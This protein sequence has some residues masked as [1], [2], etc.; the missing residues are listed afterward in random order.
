MLWTVQ[1]HKDIEH[2]ETPYVVKLHR[3]TPLA[4][5]LPVFTFQHPA[6]AKGPPD[7]SRYLSLEFKRNELPQ[8]TCHGFAGYFEA[9]L[10]GDVWLSTHPETHTPN[11]FSWFPVYFPLAEPLVIPQSRHIQ[12]HWWRCVSAHEVW[13]EWAVSEPVTSHIHNP[14]GRSYK[15]GL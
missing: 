3:Y 6:E 13:Y 2:M 9:Q 14:L 11:M 8:A 4:A 15:V 7:N 1:A 12:A 5:P 10:Y